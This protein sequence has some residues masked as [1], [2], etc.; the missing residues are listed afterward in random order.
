M[1]FGLKKYKK[2]HF[3]DIKITYTRSH[4]WTHGRRYSEI[5]KKFFGKFTRE[6]NGNSVLHDQRNSVKG[7]PSLAIVRGTYEKEKESP[8]YYG[9]LTYSVIPSFFY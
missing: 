5:R 2:R 6:L 8:V 9:R 7:K 1:K 3:V 4:Y